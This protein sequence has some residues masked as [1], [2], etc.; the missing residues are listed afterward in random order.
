MCSGGRCDGN[1]TRVGSLTNSVVSLAIDP[2]NPSTIFA[3]APHDARLFKSTDAGSTWIETFGIYPY[4]LMIDP[5]NTNTI[6]MGAFNDVE[7]STNGGTTWKG[8][9]CGG[10]ASALAVAIDPGDPNVFYFAVE[11]GWGVYKWARS[12]AACSN[13]LPSVDASSLAVSPSSPGTL[14]V[15]A[16]GSYG[17]TPGLY[18]T[19]DGGSHWTNVLASHSVTAVAI[20]PSNAAVAYVGTNVGLLESLDGGTSWI[21]PLST[22]PSTAISSILVDKMQPNVVY[23]GTQ[24]AGV[25]VSTDSGSS[26]SSMNHG[27]VDTT[28]NIVALDP[29]D[30]STL[31]AGT[32]VGVYRNVAR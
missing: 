8:V 28:I 23:L 3:G 29:T 19:T 11:A 15:G 2:N 18:K 5:T 25:L 13:L 10:V 30:P 22:V 7:Q 16:T 14:Y 6:V 9:S 32:L 27:F 21:G 12:P 4:S 1:W 26:W 20:D 17:Y 24:D 31:Y